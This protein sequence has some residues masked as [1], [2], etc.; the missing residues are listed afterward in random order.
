MSKHQSGSKTAKKSQV[1]INWDNRV[2]CSDGNCIGVIGQDGNCKECGKP[3]EGK[4]PWQIEPGQSD[5]G[6][7]VSDHSDMDDEQEETV[8]ETDTDTEE[9]TQDY[10]DWDNRKL[11]SDGNCI[12]V[13]GPDGR[14]KECGKPYEEA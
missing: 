14:C 9:K 12:G 13:I 6:P 4:L 8:A 10:S 2:L 5:P 11:C 3:Y 7:E 1:D